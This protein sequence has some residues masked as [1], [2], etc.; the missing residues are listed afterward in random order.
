[1]ISNMN[2][3][4]NEAVEFND[5]NNNYNNIVD[6]Q[7][8]KNFNPISTDEAKKQIL[9]QQCNNYVL[10]DFNPRLPITEKKDEIVTFIDTYKFCIIE[11]I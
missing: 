10:K 3:P 9:E 6:E 11:G 5:E 1:M 4:E 8:A 2:L 7:V